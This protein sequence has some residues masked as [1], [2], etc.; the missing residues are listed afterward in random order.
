[1]S[2]PKTKK[3]KLSGTSAT[4]LPHK[5]LI[6]L[7]GRMRSI[8][9]F[10]D[11]IHD[12][13]LNGLVYGTTHLCQGQEAVSAG[14]IAP[15]I[16]GDYLTYTYRGHGQCIARGMD[17]EAAFAEVFGRSTGVS[18]GLGGS[19]HLTDMDLGLIGSFAIVGA[20]LPVAAGAAM[21][22]QYE[23]KGNV[24]MTF[25]GDGSTNI[26]AFHETM[27]LAVVWNLPLLFICENNLY[28]EYSPILSTT[29]YEDIARRAEAYAMPSDIVDGN[30]AQAVYEVVSRHVERARRGGGPGF[31]ECKTYRYKGH[32]RSDPAKYRT[33]EELASW[34]EKDPLKQMVK[35]LMEN[36]I[37][38]QKEIEAIDQEISAHTDMA[39]KN[40]AEAPFPTEKSLLDETYA[41]TPLK[42]FG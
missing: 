34:M 40:A 39:A 10:E 19:M 30:D 9:A 32:S 12:S 27:N 23:E 5:V 28:G 3:V 7:Y 24:A 4:R 18:G 26:G 1:M 42:N 31:I 8:R 41:T 33:D 29:P 37:L 14:A 16:D 21:T 20:G 22:C 36:K 13:F 35:L 38:T 15:L 25:F 6:D 17:M 11:K 2:D